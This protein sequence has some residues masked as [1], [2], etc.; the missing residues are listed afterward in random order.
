MRLS[1]CL[2]VCCAAS[3]LTAAAASGAL[4]S[5]YFPASMGMVWTYEKL[6]PTATG[7]TKDRRVVC[8]DVKRNDEVQSIVLRRVCYLGDLEVAGT[9]IYSLP[10]AGNKVVHTTAGSDL[11]GHKQLTNRPVVLMLPEPGASVA[12]KTKDRDEDGNVTWVYESSAKFV[13]AT[14]TPYAEFENV[15]EVTEK[16][17]V[18]A[19]PWAE[20]MEGMGLVSEGFSSRTGAREHLSTE[21]RYYAPEVGL[22]KTLQ[23]YH[24]ELQGPVS[25]QL[26][27]FQSP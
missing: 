18:Y 3:A 14:T 17:Y 22:V 5:D 9:D 26:T 7:K 1:K 20:P 12:W 15:I 4:L 25:S 16:V 8:A 2:S 21:K 11:L 23:Y 10:D 6:E 27:K 24:G 13:P 19:G